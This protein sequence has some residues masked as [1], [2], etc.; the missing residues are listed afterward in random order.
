MATL[1]WVQGG[2]IGVI[3]LVIILGWLF[4]KETASRQVT[5]KTEL[6]SN[7]KPRK[8]KHNAYNFNRED[9]L[10]S[11]QKLMKTSGKY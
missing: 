3:V 10:A 4:F 2:S 5:F 9:S 7:S 11:L 8:K 6:T 1:L